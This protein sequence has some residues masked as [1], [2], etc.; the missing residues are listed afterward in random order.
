MP[1]T[2]EQLDEGF[3]CP[4]KIRRFL[5]AN[6]GRDA[7]EPYY[8]TE[9]LAAALKC[10]TPRIRESHGNP[11][12]INYSVAIHHKRFWSAPFHIGRLR[13]TLDA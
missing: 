6:C 13:K 12:L 7:K 2:L 8:S 11:S 5:D 1:H 9:E 3:G 4:V 10:N